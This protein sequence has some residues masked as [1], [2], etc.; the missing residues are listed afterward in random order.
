M[1]R[2]AWHTAYRLWFKIIRVDVH[3]TMDHALD[4]DGPC[5]GVDDVK[6]RVWMDGPGA[7]AFTQLVAFPTRFR[8]ER[9]HIAR[10]LKVAKKSVGTG[11]MPLCVPRGNF[12]QIVF[13]ASCFADRVPL[14][15]QG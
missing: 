11:G 1:Q 5:I 2:T 3:V 13:G 9:Q 15:S 4:D 7:Q 14:G 12:H 10:L 8:M 6:D